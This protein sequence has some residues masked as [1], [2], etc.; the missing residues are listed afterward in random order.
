MQPSLPRTGLTALVAAAL[1]GVCCAS[2]AATGKQSAP[3]TGR[4]HAV[5]PRP[6]SVHDDPARDFRLTAATTIHTATHLAA[7]G[8][9]SVAH[10][11]AAALRPATGYRLPVRIAPRD[12]GPGR[13]R[14]IWLLTSPK[15]ATGSEGYQL[16]VRPEA[17]LISART[18]AGLFAGTQTLRQLLPA[19]IDSPRQLPGPWTVPGG[20]LSDQPR[21]PHR[22]AMLD[23]ARH[24]FTVDQVKRYIDQISRYKINRLHLHLADD[25]GWRLEIRSWP[26][27]ATHGGSTQVGGGPGGYYTQAQYRDLIAYAAARHIT[28]IP[29]IDMPGHTN[30]A[31]AS[32]AELNCDGRARDLYTGI[33]VGFSCLCVTKDVTYRFIDD[34]VREVAALTPGPWLH[35]GGDEV[36]TLPADRYAEFVARAQRIVARH[37]KTPLGWH[38]VTHAPKAPN[39]LVQYWGTATTD[40]HLVAAAR[41]GSRIIMSPG[42]KAY[43]DMKYDRNTRPGLNWAGYVEVR[44]AYDWEPATRV[45]GLPAQSV[46]GVEAALWTETITTS[47]DLEYMAFPRLP[48]LAE[49]AWSPSRDWSDFRRRLAQHGARWDHAGLGFHRSPQVDWPTR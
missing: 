2:A 32:Y 8:V 40:Q 6:V 39:P 15:S 49:L 34:V 12:P 26:R 35:I 9:A 42:N 36:K 47:T 13:R 46:L 7:A 1:L 31:L 14:G 33:K 4:A 11:L 22:G 3:E 29:E 30:A 48:A 10:Q 43:L 45:A 37:G 28:V 24:F 18:P 5:I 17:V 19:T 38:E 20:H 44:D 27:L 41:D 25:Q 16:D 21:Y 23:V